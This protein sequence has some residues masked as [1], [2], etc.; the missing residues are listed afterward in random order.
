MIEMEDVFQSPQTAV[1]IRLHA[2]LQ[3]LEVNVQT[4]ET[5]VDGLNEQLGISRT[6]IDLLETALAYINRM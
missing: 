2:Y 1:L 5:K 4:L 6:R 3:Q